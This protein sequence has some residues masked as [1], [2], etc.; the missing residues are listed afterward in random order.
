MADTSPS[1][2]LASASL[3]ALADA[4]EVGVIIVDDHGRVVLWNDWMVMRSGIPVDWAR[5]RTL[6][7]VFP[8]LD[9][10]SIVAAVEDGLRQGATTMLSSASS[11]QLFPLL[12][13]DHILGQGEAMNQIVIVKPILAQDGQRLCLVQV[14]DVTSM[15]QR[16]TLLR[17]QARSMEALAGQHRQAEQQIRAIVD[18]T[19]DAIISFGHDGVIHTYNRAA[20]SI[21]GYAHA[22][23]MGKLIT[24]LVPD[25]DISRVSETARHTE[26]VGWH[27]SGRA[28]PL[29]LSLSSMEVAGRGTIIAIG[30]DITQ[31]KIVEA[32][33]KN[34]MEWLKT[35]VNALPDLVCL[36]D[37][38]GRWLVANPH[39]LKVAGLETAKDYAGQTSAQL[40]ARYGGNAQTL[41]VLECHGDHGLTCP[42]AS[43]DQPVK[44]P[45]NSDGVYDITT[46]PLFYDDGNFRGLVI[47]AR[48]VTERRLAAQRISHMAHHDSL[49]G[50]PNRELFQERLRQ[51]LALTRRRRDKMAL[52]F[53]DLDKF[54]E[55]N[56]SLGHHVG[57]LLLQAVAQRLRRCVRETD[58]VARLGGDEFAIILTQLTDPAGAGKVAESIIEAIAAPFN[59]DGHDIPTSTSVGI[60]MAPDDSTHPDQLL[61]NADLAMFRSKAEGRN[62]FHFYVT[63]MDVEIQARKVIER[64]LRQAVG[65]DQLRLHYQPLVEVSS[66]L[67]VGCEA[68]IRWLHPQRGWVSPTDF[69]PVAERSDVIQTLGRWVLHTACCQ[70]QEW[71]KAG[72]PPL[73]IAVNLSPAQFKHRGLVDIIANTLTLTAMPPSQLQLEITEGI[74]M[75]NVDQ[76]LDILRQLRSMGAVI[77]IDDFGTGYAS[78]NYL[79]RFP[80]DKLKV[81]RSLVMD[82][83][84]HPDNEA[85]L[86]AI[87]D[88]GHSLGMRVNVEGVETQEQMDYLTRM[89]VDE[90]QGFLFSQAVPADEFA[91]LVRQSM[92]F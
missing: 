4:A 71:A 82:I 22:E 58:T 81:D 67:I 47:I 70:A 2:D 33:T 61:K 63:Q 59:L 7:E 21:F 83:G 12:H 89:R 46:L 52:M 1:I 65:T 9:Q 38:Y 75:Q 30:H 28:F 44:G 77:S 87:V 64:D 92:G 15:A 51:A 34:Q 49:T 54:K 25:L 76:T 78:L 17:R 20:E 6:D 32:D 42:I 8:D 19:A 37:E 84:R 57:D 10:S 5:N 13:E 62:N 23:M 69:I 24:L 3:N 73:K 66:G 74:A 18:N 36:K 31:R 41:A 88:L 16:E 60:T 79:K 26:T 14:F 43:Y 29:E 45:E 11:G 72:L 39:F 85:V 53:L 55:V 56:D 86:K 48:D 80:V 91:A 68:L 90:A 35:L 27:R 50:L 40:L